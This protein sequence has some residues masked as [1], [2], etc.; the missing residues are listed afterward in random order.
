MNNIMQWNIQSLRTHFSDLKILLRDHAPACICL[1]ETLVGNSSIMPPSQYTA[2]QSPTVRQD[3]HERGA[4]ILVNNQIFHQRI[5]LNTNLQAV[6]IKVSLDKLYNICSL[7]L[8]H[9]EVTVQEIQSLIDQLPP[10]FLILGDMNARSPIWENN[11]TSGTNSKGRI[12]EHLLYNNNISILNDGS[13]THYHI[14][15]NSYTTIDL[16]IC[17]SDVLLTFDYSVLN[18]TYGSDHFPAKLALRNAG[19]VINERPAAYKVDRADWTSFHSLSH[20]DEMLENFNGVDDMLSYLE[21][22][23]R[24]AADAT[25]PKTNTTSAKPPIPWWNRELAN[26]RRERNRRERALRRRYSIENKIAYNRAKA[27]LRFLANEAR[28]SS[29]KN[30]VGSINQYTSLHKIWKKVQRISGKYR[31]PPRTILRDQNGDVVTDREE[32]AEVMAD[33]FSSISSCINYPPRF[34]QYKN[35]IESRSLHFETRQDFPYNHEI[36]TRE[37]EAALSH[38]SNSAPGSDNIP[39]ILIKMAHHTYRNLLLNL[40]NRIFSERVYPNHWRLAIVL[41]FPKPGKD[42]LDVNCKRPISLTQCMAKVMERIINTRLVWFL[43]SNNLISEIQSGFRPARSTTDNL[44][45]LDTAI[46]NSLHNGKHFIAIFFDLQK[47]YDTALRRGILENLHRY[48]MRGILPIF[49]QKFLTNRKIRVR[50]GHIISSE[51]TIEEG[52]PQGSVL[53]CTLFSIAINEI[54]K[55]LP[56]TVQCSLYVDDFALFASGSSTHDRATTTNSYLKA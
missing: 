19:D 49:L 34:L 40:Y 25:I 46:K 35:T 15:S 50:N 43:E 14:Q 3:G 56:P 30:Y 1:Q 18:S 17:S 13:P 26:A 38:S 51:K 5:Q 21:D 8:P 33:H 37:F 54:C 23:L 22:H 11:N 32:V 36:T 55:D 4:A 29:W 2:Y 12:F 7:Y 31:A 44:I 53:S 10:P 52:V 16:H 27:K 24:G 45:T 6:A 9:V 39:Y 20:T 28:R 48:R 41:G 42:P 47:A